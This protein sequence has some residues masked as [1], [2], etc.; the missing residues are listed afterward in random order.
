MRLDVPG[1]QRP[2]SIDGSMGEAPNGTRSA[3]ASAAVLSKLEDLM[4]RMKNT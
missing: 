1:T 4:A 3:D 2:E